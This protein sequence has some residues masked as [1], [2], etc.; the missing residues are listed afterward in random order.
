V[1]LLRVAKTVLLDG[2]TGSVVK[3]GTINA[4]QVFQLNHF[5]AVFDTENDRQVPENRY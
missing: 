3:K 4:S 2:K 5:S 1:G